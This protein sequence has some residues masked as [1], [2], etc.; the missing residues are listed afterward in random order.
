M[1]WML[2]AQSAGA[3]ARCGH[4]HVA[5]ACCAMAR[6]REENTCTP[7]RDYDGRCGETALV[8]LD[9]VAKKE[10]FSWTSEARAHGKGAR[11]ATSNGQMMHEVLQC[12]I[13]AKWMCNSTYVQPNVHAIAILAVVRRAK[14]EANVSHM[15]YAC[16]FRCA[17][18]DHRL[19][20]CIWPIW[21]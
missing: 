7:P 16:A 1:Q 17:C 21:F 15:Q 6:G 12:E 19:C 20:I 18:C 3:K 14:C 11:Q 4:H 8:D 2:I 5:F 9:T 10:D 13:H